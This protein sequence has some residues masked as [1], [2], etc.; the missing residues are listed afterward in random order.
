MKPL[1]AVNSSIQDGVIHLAVAGE[2]DLSAKP[3]LLDQIVAQ[4][5]APG[6][7]AM[8]V[9]LS[10]LTFINK[11]GISILLSCKRHADRLGRS[12]TATGAQGE[13]AKELD[14]SGI[15]DYLATD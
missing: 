8:V 5:E 1:F 9:D 12:F 13:V 3:A 4:L 2:V 6:V 14:L 15:A 7:T 10:G 11:A